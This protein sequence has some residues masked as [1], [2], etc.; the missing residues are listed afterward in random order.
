MSYDADNLK[1]YTL[2]GGGSGEAG[3][4]DFSDGALSQDIPTQMMKIYQWSAN[5]KPDSSG[6]NLYTN[7]ILT[8]AEISS[9]FLTFTRQTMFDSSITCYYQLTG[10]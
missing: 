4:F 1:A 5:V 2:P 10:Y 7:A 3:I 9:G 8:N 6:R